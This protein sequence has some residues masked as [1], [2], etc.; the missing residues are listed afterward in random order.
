MVWSFLEGSGPASGAGS[1][2][3]S[4]FFQSL[5]WPIVSRVAS[6]STGRLRPC[7]Q[8]P[9]MALYSAIRLCVRLP[10]LATRRSCWVKKVCCE[11]ST[12]WKSVSPSRYCTVAMSSE[13]RAAFTAS[14]RM[15]ICSP[16]VAKPTAASSTS[17]AARSTASWYCS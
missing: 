12:R 16:V 15:A 7:C 3:A 5:R 10:R 8:P 6:S 9:P 14:K 17:R 2:A 1:G 4:R 11:S 13:R